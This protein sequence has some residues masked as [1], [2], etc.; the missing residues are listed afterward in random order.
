MRIACVQSKVVFGDS[1]ANADRAASKL[2]ELKKQGVDFAVFPEA[3]LTGYC[4][5]NGEAAASIA[6]A[7]DGEAICR[8]RAVCDELDM[9]LV[10]GFAEQ[11]GDEL[12]NTAVLLEPGKAPRFYRKTHLPYLGLD[13]FVC[14]GSALDVFDT[15]LGRIGILI[16]FDLRPPEAARVLA[17]QGADLIVLPTNWPVGAE[18]SADHIAI[19]RAAENRVFIATCNRVGLENGFT[20]IGRSKL[21]GVTGNVL[22]AAGGEEETIVADFDLEQARSKRTVTIPGEYETEVF[23]SRNPGLYRPIAATP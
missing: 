21:I 5:G 17:L 20:F 9:L 18:I 1:L 3:Y 22:A 4:V 19:T 6:I 13:R 11:D 16:C 23:A 12:Y 14:A 7:K 8:L 10:A 2:H 15:R